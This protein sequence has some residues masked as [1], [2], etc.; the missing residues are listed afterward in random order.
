MTE[1]AKRRRL[2]DRYRLDGVLGRGGMSEVHDGY[3]ERLDRPVAIKLLRP[4]AEPSLGEL[5]AQGIREGQERD[6]ARLLR[7]V[8]TTAGLEL[9]GTPAIYAPVSRS[10]AVPSSCGW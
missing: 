8:R 10:G 1:D 6:R 9:P 2:A 7:E 5:T 3:D 4:S